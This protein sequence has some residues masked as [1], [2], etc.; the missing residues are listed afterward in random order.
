[1]LDPITTLA[2]VIGSVIGTLSLDIGLNTVQNYFDT[3]YQDSFWESA[4]KDPEIQ[5][6]LNEEE[7]QIELIFQQ[8]NFDTQR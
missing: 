5:R 8:T 1:M 7:R 4:G 6:N 2:V 3:F